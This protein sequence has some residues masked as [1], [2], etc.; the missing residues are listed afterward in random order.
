ME[1]WNGTTSQDDTVLL[2]HEAV[3]EINTYGLLP[4]G[5]SV[6]QAQMLVRGPAQHSKTFLGHENSFVKRWSEKHSESAYPVLKNSFCA[7]FAVATKIPGYSPDSG[8]R[9]LWIIA[10]AGVISRSDRIGLW[11][12]RAGNKVG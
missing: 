7:L 9:S 1:R 12:R 4:R 5:M 10:C 6:R 3:G 8:H 2:F 11:T